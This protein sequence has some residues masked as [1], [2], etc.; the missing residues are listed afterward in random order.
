MIAP[1]LIQE[2]MEVLGSDGMH[3]GTVDHIEGV[4]SVML[5]KDDPDAGGQS[6]YI[7]LSWVL[8][9]E[10][11]VHLKQPAAEAKARWDLALNLRSVGAAVLTTA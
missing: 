3:V 1:I 6:H 4:D 2:N 11:K 9:V 10:M 5:A 8:H 7:P